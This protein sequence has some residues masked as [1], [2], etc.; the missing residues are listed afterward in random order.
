MLWIMPVTNDNKF[1]KIVNEG[2]T[3]IKQ[4]TEADSNADMTYEYELLQ[5]LGVAIMFNLRFAMYDIA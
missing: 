4:V 3:Q 5:K 1:I 2:D